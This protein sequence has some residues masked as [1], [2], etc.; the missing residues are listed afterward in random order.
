MKRCLLV[1]LVLS[2][3]FSLVSCSKS[4]ALTVCDTNGNV[5]ATLKKAD[6]SDSQ[7]SDPTYRSYVEL[8]LQ[9]AI[10]A[11]S[12]MYG[13]DAEKATKMLFQEQM[14]LHTAFDPV[15][16]SA[17]DTAYSEY[18]EQNL[19]FGCAILDSNGNICA[20]Y[21]GGGQQY[22]LMEHSPF[23]TIKPL[24]VYAPAMEKQLIDWS[25]SFV[26]KPYKQI[27][28]ED[29][30]INDWPMNAGAAFTYEKTLLVECI[31]RSL[32]TAAVF[33][34]NDLGVQNSVDFL[35]TSFGMDL[36][37]EQN[38]ITLQ[39]EE[40]VIGN[41]AMGYLNKGFTPAQLAG[42][43][44]IF[45]KAGYYSAPAALINIEDAEGNTLWQHKKSEKQVISEETAYLM[46]RLLLNVVSLGGTGEEAA[47][48][49]VELI[50]KTGT[51]NDDGGNWFVGVTPEYSCAVWHGVEENVKS[52]N[53][54]AKLFASVFENMPEHTEKEF[55]TCS[56]IQKSVFC[57]ESG[58]L[59]SSRCSFMDIGYYAYGRKPRVCAGH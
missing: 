6:F 14:V 26:D 39:G 18:A 44:Q 23:S 46:N 34:L 55:K 21:S 40:E 9:E 35:Q 47:L 57:S 52:K 42:Y 11:I 58:G 50:G 27:T 51:G 43:Y 28:D 54:A 37:Y 17:I 20:V 32:N 8:S 1:F 22:A 59:F 24:G 38:K 36:N 10:S 33:C 49:N 25:S 4:G 5:I 19:S 3:L 56:Q 2:L 7:L 15:M 53:I 31:K 30:S 41:I 16:N 12:E 13:Y 29:G 45:G 48:S